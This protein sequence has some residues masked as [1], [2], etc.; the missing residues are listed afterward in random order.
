MKDDIPP[1]TF[2]PWDAPVVVSPLRSLVF[3]CRFLVGSDT[4]DSASRYLHFPPF[5]SL[6][7]V[8]DALSQP[9]RETLPAVASGSAG[10]AGWARTSLQPR[11]TP[12][13]WY[14]GSRIKL[15]GVVSLLR[16]I[17]LT[18][19]CRGS[20]VSPLKNSAAVCLYC[21]C[22]CERVIVYVGGVINRISCVSTY[23]Y[24]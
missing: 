23:R 7:W 17:Y 6:R 2:T 14:Q 16:Q 3:H 13:R 19:A 20:T 24:W 18:S 11:Q 15:L 12:D 21:V 8:A 1:H 22:V 5:P 10:T 9:L 4:R